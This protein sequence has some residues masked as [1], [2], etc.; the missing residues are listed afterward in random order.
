M[1]QMPAR[2]SCA[3]TSASAQS[4]M[5]ALCIAEPIAFEERSSLR[6]ADSSA[7]GMWSGRLSDGMA[8]T[9]W[10]II[11]SRTVC[12]STSS[13][14]GR[15][16]SPIASPSK[17]RT[18]TWVSVRPRMSMVFVSGFSSCRFLG[19]RVLWLLGRQVGAWGNRG[20]GAKARLGRSSSSP[21]V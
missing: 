2:S 6:P 20:N 18:A 21:G 3:L 8:N 14:M 16:A 1:N 15:P 19:W 7:S 13:G 17:G 4:K 12:Q 5:T 11:S 10:A 9:V